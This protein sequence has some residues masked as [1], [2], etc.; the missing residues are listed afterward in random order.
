MSRKPKKPTTAAPVTADI[1]L[2]RREAA[3]LLGLDPDRLTASDRLK[4]ELVAALRAAVDD[5]LMNVTSAR[6][7]DLAKLITAVETLTRFLQ[8]AKPKEDERGA[9]FKR[10]PYKVLDELAERWRQADEATRRD[11]GLSPRISDPEEAQARIDDLEAELVRLRGAQP[12][13]LP[14]PEVEKAIDVPTSAILPPGEQA[15][16]PRNQ[17]YAPDLKRSG[18]PVTIEGTKLPPGARLVN[19]R[20]EPIPPQA[21]SGAE[22][23]A[24]RQRVNADRSLM[25]KVMNAPSRVA[26]EPQPSTPLTTYGDSN[27]FFGG[28]KGRAW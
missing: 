6:S 11:Q 15:D 14:S 9:I 16:N 21:K 19:G 28:E 7:V 22:T 10:D 1:A 23:E 4:C 13:A 18:P 24:Q 27:F 3:Q 20:I 2:A 5:E 8:D 26:H 25:H 17:D 12:H